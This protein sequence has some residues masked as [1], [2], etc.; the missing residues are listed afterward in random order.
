MRL[1]PPQ[2][3][4]ER[5]QIPLEDEFS[6]SQNSRS[7]KDTSRP[8]TNMT[9]F[10]RQ[11]HVLRQTSRTRQ[12]VATSR[13]NCT[14]YRQRIE[15]RKHNEMRIK[16]LRRRHAGTSNEML[17]RRVME[18]RNAKSSFSQGLSIPGLGSW[19]LDSPEILSIQRR[20]MVDTRLSRIEG[21]TCDALQVSFQKSARRLVALLTSSVLLID[22]VA[23][24][25]IGTDE[26]MRREDLNAA[27]ESNIAWNLRIKAHWK[28]HGAGHILK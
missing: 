5:Q 22:M 19:K 13:R 17:L 18:M 27:Q 12:R 11:A 9:R 2:P 20:Q 24:R 16:S 14:T 15:Y 7:Q 6:S 25:M 3:N 26:Q 23:L 4:N 28:I 8:F 1:L 10:A 21:L